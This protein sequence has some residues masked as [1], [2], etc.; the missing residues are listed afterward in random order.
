MQGAQSPMQGAVSPLMKRR[1]PGFKYNEWENGDQTLFSNQILEIA[2]PGINNID[3]LNNQLLGDRMDTKSP[4]PMLHSQQPPVVQPK[5]VET[6]PHPTHHHHHANTRRRSQPAHQDEEY[7]YSG[8][9]EPYSASSQESADELP[10]IHA[11]DGASTSEI[12][13]DFTP[14]EGFLPKKEGERMTMVVGPGRHQVKEFNILPINL[15]RVHYPAKSSD[16]ILVKLICDK[17]LR[18]E[19]REIF[20]TA[21]SPQHSVNDKGEVTLPNLKISQTMLPGRTKGFKFVL[22]Y[23]LISDGQEVERLVSEPFHIWSN[24]NQKGYPRKERD[25]YIIQRIKANSK[26]RRRRN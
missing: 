9:S 25:L 14:E 22:T 8:D 19:E 3:N 18:K 5:P 6:A 20:M 21:V 12:E 23:T 1:D 15:L 24:V 4:P 13:E 26:K 2:D 10:D 7:Y 17:K 11:G 16:Y